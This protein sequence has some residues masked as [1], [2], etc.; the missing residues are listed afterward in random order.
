MRNF[1]ADIDLIPLL[2]FKLNAPV[3]EIAVVAAC[4]EKAASF[5][6]TEWYLVFCVKGCD[7]AQIIRIQ[8]VQRLIWSVDCQVFAIDISKEAALSLELMVGVDFLKISCSVELFRNLS[9]PRRIHS[10]L[11]MHPEL[12]HSFFHLLLYRFLSAFKLSLVFF[13]LILLFD[14][15]SLQLA[16]LTLENLHLFR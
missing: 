2:E 1:I 13:N 10:S 15:H 7:E 16:Y 4:E 5:S 9:E 14:H 12:S 3:E 6:Y 11:V 8:D